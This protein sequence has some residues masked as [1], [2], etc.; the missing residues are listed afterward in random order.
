MKIKFRIIAIMITVSQLL[1]SCEKENITDQA[2]QNIDS[3][4]TRSIT[5]SEPNGGECW[6]IGDTENISWYSEGFDCDVKIELH[7]D[8]SFYKTISSQTENSQNYIWKIPENI[9]LSSNYKILIG[10]ID[11]PETN[12]ISASSFEIEKEPYL[13]VSQPNYLTG[14]GNDYYKYIKWDSCGAGQK[15]KIQL[16][17]KASNGHESVETTITQSTDNDGE[18]HWKVDTDYIGTYCYRIMVSST[19]SS[20]I[21]GYSDYFSVTF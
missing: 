7:K 6:E 16:L 9:D 3:V 15:V 21:Y 5:V 4:E 13:K 2:S 11:F 17:F 19:S 14:W 1:L 10:S 18:Y 12:G 20:S 8:N